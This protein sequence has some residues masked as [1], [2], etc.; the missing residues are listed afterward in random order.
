[1]ANKVYNMEGGL[2]SAA[3]YSAFEDALYGSCVA[4]ESD[5]VCT[6]GTGM[7]VQ[8]TAGQ[9]LISTGTGYARRIGSDSTNT[10]TVSAASTANPRID[11]IVAYIDNSVTPTTSV[12]DNTNDILKFKAVAGSPAASPVAPSAATIQSSVG[13]GNPYMVLWTVRVPA[14]A[15][16]LATA[17]FTDVRT[18]AKVEIGD[19]SITT[20][21]LA[22][23][24]VNQAKTDLSSFGAMTYLGALKVT[25]ATTAATFTLPA[26]Y[27]NYKLRLVAHNDTQDEIWFDVR[28]MNGTSDLATSG[29]R[30]FVT[31]ATWSCQQS[32]NATFVGATQ[33][34]ASG[35]IYGGIEIVR[36]SSAYWRQIKADLTATRGSLASFAARFN[37]RIESDTEITGFKLA[38]GGNMSAGSYL[39][40]WGWN[41]SDI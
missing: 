29:Y 38:S 7:T 18:F 36:A 14:N 27:D 3:A 33:V 39:Q 12:V 11:A 17:T 41:N 37:G 21:K 19:G 8:L 5:F 35:H 24:A 30:E 2:H 31:N 25:A 13:A 32:A 28:A 23:E 1:M 15:T 6:A 10:I 4:S 22:D 16:S 9:G 34:P 40:I 26:R 20:P